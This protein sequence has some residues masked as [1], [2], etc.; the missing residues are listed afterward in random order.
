[1]ENA[2][3]NY[4]EQ[5]NLP[6]E[7]GGMMEVAKSK[8]AQE[9]QA[10]VIMAKRF[11]RNQ[12]VAEKRILDACKRKGLAE[13]SQYTF[14]RGKESVSGPSIRLAEMLAANWGN[15]DF[16]VIEIDRSNGV[17]T[18]QSYCWDLE[19]NVRQ[20]KVFTIAH[21]RNTKR[22]SYA[23][24]DERDIYE[25][26]ANN[27]ARRLRACIL[28][29]IPGDIVDA[30]LIECDKTLS[31][32]GGK[33]AKPMKER[34]SEMAKLFE[35]FGVTSDLI[36]KRMG[37]PL[38]VERTTESEMVQM[39]KIFLALQ[40]NMAKPEDYFEMPKA[41]AEKSDLQKRVEAATANSV[42]KQEVQPTPP[43]NHQ[44]AVNHVTSLFE[45]DNPT[46]KGE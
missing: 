40:D 24:T 9:I 23:L 31:G 37:H 15:L 44:P 36:E 38:T 14:P 33:D 41:P 22:G 32:A 5:E 45:T 16:G 35:R 7:V 10:M 11:P 2:P 46:L 17:S 1:M 34:L 26:V 20:T 3:A 25:M 27:G 18:V 29:I 6:A 28:G 42:A 39:K 13:S 8:A 4:D 30:A 21:T 19:T 12:L 43:L